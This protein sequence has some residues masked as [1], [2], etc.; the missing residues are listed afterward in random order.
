MDIILNTLLGSFIY[1]DMEYSFVEYLAILVDRK[2]I[3]K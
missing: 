3:Y 2:L 1:Y